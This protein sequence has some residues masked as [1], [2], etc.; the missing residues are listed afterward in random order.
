M[1][2]PPDEAAPA[3]VYSSGRDITRI[4]WNLGDFDPNDLEMVRRYFEWLYDAAVDPDEHDIQN[5]RWNL[6]FPEVADRFRMIPDGGYDVIVDYPKSS[7]RAIEALVEQLRTRERSPR[8][9]LRQLQQ[10]TV[11]LRAGGA[12]RLLREGLIEEIIPGVGRWHGDYNPVRGLTEADPER[13]I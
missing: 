9:I 12:E 7:T 6:N 13:I 8:E 11:S 10:H 4:L 2:N 1:F 3:G 5:L